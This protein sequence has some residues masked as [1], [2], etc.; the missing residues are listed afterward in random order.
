MKK[1]TT[2]AMIIVLIS[3]FFIIGQVKAEIECPAGEKSE[4]VLIQEGQEAFSGCIQ[5]SKFWKDGLYRSDCKTYYWWG[6]WGGW[7]DWVE[8][9]AI[10]PV[11]EWQCVVDPDYVEPEE[12]EEEEE[13]ES[14]EEEMPIQVILSPAPLGGQMSMQARVQYLLQGNSGQIELAEQLM[15]EYF[16]LFPEMRSERQI[17]IDNLW[18]Q[19]QE[20]QRRINE[21]K[22]L[23]K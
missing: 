8:K 17:M 19:I 9:E 11:Y 13:E 12:P 15:K 10:D 1:N 6:G 20:L 3:L 14:A 16:W 4:Y 7:F 22:A 5:V 21:L 2:I 23:I 18:A